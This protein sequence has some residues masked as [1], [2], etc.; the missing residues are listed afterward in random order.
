MGENQA[1]CPWRKGE[2]QTGLNY[3]KFCGKSRLWRECQTWLA[4][5]FSLKQELNSNLVCPC[6]GKFG[7]T[8]IM[9]NNSDGPL[10][11][12]DK[13][14][15]INLITYRKSG[16]AVPTPVWFKVMGDHIY[17]QTFGG[18]GKIKRIA[19]TPH[20]TVWAS[21]AR[22]GAVGSHFEAIA[23]IITDPAEQDAA[24]AMLQGK[25]GNKRTIFYQQIGLDRLQ[26]TYL[27]ITPIIS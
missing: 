22:G 21:D 9:Q 5:Q 1:P 11:G 6:L 4:K 25:Y 18:A 24:E 8:V 20:V 12:L 15:F 3:R 26:M 13:Y 2:A 27:E 19:H 14:E 16:V 10:A 17:V 7:R 23:R